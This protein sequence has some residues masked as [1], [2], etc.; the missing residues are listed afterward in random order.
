MVLTVVAAAALFGVA[1]LTIDVGMLCSSR[2][3][4]QS[5]VDAAALAG[6]Q[7]LPRRSDACYWACEC[8]LAN[9]EEFAGAQLTVPDDNGVECY[10]P[11]ET[12]PGYGTLGPDRHAI[13][14]NATGT[15]DYSFAGAMGHDTA[16]VECSATAIAKDCSGWGTIFVEQ[17][18]T[19]DNAHVEITGN[20]HSNDQMIFDGADGFIKGDTTYVNSIEM[21]HCTMDFQGAVQSVPYRTVPTSCLASDFTVDY[22]I[23]AGD[24]PPMTGAVCSG[25]NITAQ[26]QPVVDFSPG[27]YECNDLILRNCG[28]ITGDDVTFVVHGRVILDNNGAVELSAA[29]HDMAIYATGTDSRAIELDQG[30]PIEVT[31]GVCAP[32]GGIYFDR[33]EIRVTNGL[34]YSKSLYIDQAGTIMNTQTES[35]GNAAVRLIK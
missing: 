12:V 4:V 33:S 16:T 35:H 34:V 6:A 25:G 24:T 18:I 1:A 13:T 5:S 29:Q 22:D 14:V 32:D 8:V 11:R 7:H 20:T 19:T 21:S 15:F 2:Q 3:H 9:D 28:S 23:T 17:V 30:Q 27:V 10:G 31:G 26:G